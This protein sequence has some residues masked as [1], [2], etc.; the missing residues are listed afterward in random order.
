MKQE[1][2]YYIDENKNKWD[3]DIY[4]EDQ[5][6][7]YSESL[8]NCFNCSDCSDWKSNP[9]RITSPNIG[10]RDSQTTIYFDSERTQVVC[11]C[12]NDTLDKFKL[13]VKETHGD[14]EHSK[15]YFKWIESV[16]KYIKS[17]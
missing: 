14:N 16:E 12:F 7:K 8:I 4:T 10:S 17:L 11:G 1:N 3:C 5:A 9:Q 13:K 6:Q 15:A 2:G